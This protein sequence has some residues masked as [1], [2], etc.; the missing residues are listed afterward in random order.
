MKVVTERDEL[1]NARVI[2]IEVADW[3]MAEG[4][5]ELAFLQTLQRAY[6]VFEKAKGRQEIET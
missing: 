4:T 1:R 2:R 5:P 3:E 6:E